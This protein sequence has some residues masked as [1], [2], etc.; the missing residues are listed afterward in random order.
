[1]VWPGTEHGEYSTRERPRGRAGN[2]S[3]QARSPVR[4]GY[5]RAR[6]T[7]RPPRGCGTAPPRPGPLRQCYP[8]RQQAGAALQELGLKDGSRGDLAGR[9]GR[10]HGGCVRGGSRQASSPEPSPSSSA[11]SRRGGGAR[12]LFGNAAIRLREEVNGDDSEPRRRCPRRRRC[13]TLPGVSRPPL[14]R[15]LMQFCRGNA[16]PRAFLGRFQGD[17]TLVPLAHGLVCSLRGR[18]P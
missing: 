13:P 4:A 18:Q 14:L 3:R 15:Y 8:P 7:R 16:N 12:H 6:F 10:A 11:P 2:Q 17:P 9:H 5:R 1:V